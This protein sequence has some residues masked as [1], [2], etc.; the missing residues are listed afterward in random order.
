[1]F[2]PVL[3]LSEFLRPFHIHGHREYGYLL[4]YDWRRMVCHR[5]LSSSEEALGFSATPCLSSPLKRFIKMRRQGILR[6]AWPERFQTLAHLTRILSNRFFSYRDPGRLSK[7]RRISVEISLCIFA[8]DFPILHSCI[9]CRKP[10]VSMI[11]SR[12]SSGKSVSFSI[13]FP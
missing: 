13:C 9:L 7:V 3:S 12:L 10:G 5:Q 1:M 8:R 6:P 11:T 4:R 2:Q